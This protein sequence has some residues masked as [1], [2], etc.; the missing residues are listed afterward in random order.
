MKM[1]NIKVYIGV[2]IIIAILIIGLL[3]FRIKKDNKEKND[4]EN[5]VYQNISIN[6]IISEE[7]N[8]SEYEKVEINQLKQNVGITGNSELY[9][10]QEDFYNTKVVTVKSSVKYK[11]AFSGMIKN[12]EPEIKELDNITKENHPKYAGI[13]IYENDRET[14]LNLLKNVTKSDYKIDEDGYLRILDKNN[15]NDNDKKLEK[16]IKGSKLYIIR[17][18][19]TCYIVDDV[20][21]EILDYNF[22]NIDKYQTYEYFEDDDKMI[23]FI[24]ENK[25]E[26]LKDDNIINSVINLL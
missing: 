21:G 14:F 20:T 6:E 7:N 10:V 15:Q 11:V 16:I 26:Q 1:K 24:T 13:W 25:N 4:I 23:I 8:I 9:E 17:I 22:E 19:S 18:S 2:I 3:F 5:N 12:G